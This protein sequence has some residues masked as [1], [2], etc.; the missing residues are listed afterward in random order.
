MHKKYVAISSIF[1]FCFLYINFVNNHFLIFHDPEEKLN[2]SLADNF[3]K[4]ITV[5]QQQQQQQPSFLCEFGHISNKSS[6][7]K[8]AII[9][10]FIPP[11][12]NDEEK[13][14]TGT[15]NLTMIKNHTT[16]SLLAKNKLK[17]AEKNNLDFCQMGDKILDKNRPI[18]WSKILIMKKILET[19]FYDYIIWMDADAI[20][21]R[22]EKEE[23]ENFQKLIFQFINKITNRDILVF[24]DVKAHPRKPFD[25]NTPLNTG[26]MLLKNTN[27]VTN[28]LDVIYQAEHNTIF[29]HNWEQE[30]IR[31]YRMNHEDWSL[32]YLIKDHNLIQNI[33]N[34][35]NFG[36]EENLIQHFAGGNRDK[37]KYE[38]IE[39]FIDFYHLY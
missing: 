5:Q 23:V 19:N 28:W 7:T 6:S 31:K 4:N 9:S 26:I 20:F 8:G 24:T 18:A 15:F 37:Q 39:K 38:K 1:L 36:E 35:L 3:Q 14:N 12:K 16:K 21:I 33:G 34:S 25:K 30:E 11:A 29:H 32:H 17:F 2:I 22:F 13:N 27:W 10:F